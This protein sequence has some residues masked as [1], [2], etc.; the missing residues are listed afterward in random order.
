MSSGKL[1]VK[2][3]INVGMFTVL[4]IIF[5]FVGGMIG[6]IPILMPIVP[7][8]GGI[9]AGPVYMLFAT[10]IRKAGMIFIQQM[11]L[12]LVFV[13]TG[14]GPWMLLTAGISGVLAEIIIRKG[15]YKSVHYAR[16]A[17]TVASLSGSGNFFPIYFAR[18]AYIEKMN[19]MGYGQDFADAMM[20]VLPYWSLIPIM[21]GGMLG[22]YIGCSIGIKMLRKHFVKSGMIK[23]A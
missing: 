10:K 4:T 22:M 20:S 21:L 15:D 2:D 11:V 18:E 8:V 5:V 14:H 16:L 9:L 19:A 6:F 7:M 1:N 12:A 3:L 13:A 17:F 23:G